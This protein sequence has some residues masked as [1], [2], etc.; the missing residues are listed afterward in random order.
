VLIC[1]CADDHTQKFNFHFWI[2]VHCAE[3][4]TRIGG[5]SCFDAFVAAF[6]V[7]EKYVEVGPLLV[8]ENTLVSDWTFHIPIENAR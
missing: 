6:G 4:R 1:V 5:M 7:V 8:N 3:A 2:F